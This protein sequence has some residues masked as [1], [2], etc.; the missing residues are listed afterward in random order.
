MNCPYGIFEE[1]WRGIDLPKHLVTAMEKNLQVED[2]LEQ[3]PT[4]AKMKGE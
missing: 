1:S 3:I 4:E 2:P